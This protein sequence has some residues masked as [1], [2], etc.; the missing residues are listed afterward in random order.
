M[1]KKTE[2]AVQVSTEEMINKLVSN[3]SK[4]LDEYMKLDQEQVDKIAKAMALAGLSAQTELAKMAVEETG[5]GIFEDKV[6]KNIF[7]TEYIWHSI[8]YEKTVGVIEDNVDEGYLEIGEPVGIVAG[9]TPVTN[10]TSTTMFKSIICAK[11]R[12]PIIFGFHP[13]AQKCSVRAAEIVRDAAIAAGAPEYC[14]QWIETPSI[15]ATGMLMNHPDVAT[16]LA[17]GGPGMVRAAYSAGKPALGVGPGNTP[18]YIEK[19]AKLKQAVND[20]ILS[21]SF[22]NGMICAS[23]QAAIIDSEVYDEAVKLM[24]DQG[25]W[26]APKSDIDKIRDVVINVEKMAVQPWVV[27]QYPW[28]IAEKA[29]ITIPKET[30]VLCVELGGT[31]ASKYPLALEKLSPVLAVVKADSADH[32]FELCEEMLKHGAGHTAVIHTSDDKLAEKYGEHMR[33][34]RIVVN[35]PASFGA[36]GDVYNVIA[37]SLTRLRLIRKELRIRER[38]RK[39]PHQP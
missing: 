10:P 28:Q 18:C 16:I 37:P 23:E 20:L 31:D 27:G 35:S 14:V 29:G 3:A 9:V 15:E 25:C 6:T 34:S 7:S 22:D 39:E 1:A 33:A 8:K 19:T 17:T 12:N 21:K 13:N 11:T 30:K 36:I 38:D 5:R 32:A 2:E 4:A 26:F 24:K